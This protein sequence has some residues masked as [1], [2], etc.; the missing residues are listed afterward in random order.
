MFPGRSGGDFFIDG[1]KLNYRDIRCRVIEF[2]GIYRHKIT[3]GQNTQDIGPTLPDTPN[4]PNR[5]Y[6]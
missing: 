3:E 6:T 5:A 4:P 1:Q 2:V